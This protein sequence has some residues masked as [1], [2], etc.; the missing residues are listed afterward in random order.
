M[1]FTPLHL[2]KKEEKRRRDNGASLHAG[3]WARLP[4]PAEELL[5]EL[6]EYDR[7]NEVLPCSGSIPQSLKK[8]KTKKVARTV[9]IRSKSAE[10]S[11]VNSKVRWP[12]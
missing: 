12:K 10:Q 5:I 1:S 11:W 6:G 3:L 9:N 2:G 7:M 4:S 8:K